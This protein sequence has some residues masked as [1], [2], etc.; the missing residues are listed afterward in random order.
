MDIH[1]FYSFMFPMPDTG[2]VSAKIVQMCLLRCST[3][4]GE[5]AFVQAGV[6]ANQGA[7]GIQPYFF[8]ESYTVSNNTFSHD[9]WHQLHM[10]IAV[11]ADHTSTLAVWID[12]IPATMSAKT[13]TWT[14]DLDTV[15]VGTPSTNAVATFYLKD[16]RLEY[17]DTGYTPSV[18][19]VA[20]WGSLVVPQTN[21]SVK[22]KSF[23]AANVTATLHYGA[24]DEYGTDVVSAVA[25]K[26]HEA[27]LTGL[28]PAVTYHYQ[29][30]FV[31]EAATG[32]TWKTE[33]RT[34]QLKA[35]AVTKL[36]IVSDPQGSGQGSAAATQYLNRTAGI[37]GIITPG[38][39]C[40]VGDSQVPAN[41]WLQPWALL[42]AL[43]NTANRSVWIPAIGNHDTDNSGAQPYYNTR[44]M[45][46]FPIPS[47]EAGQP[48]YSIDYGYAH[49]AVID[50]TEGA[51]GVSISA[52]CLAWLEA[53][54]KVSEKPWKF[55][56]GH[57]GGVDMIGYTATVPWLS[58]TSRHALHAAMLA[59]KAHMYIHG[60]SHN[61]VRFMTG[62]ILYLGMSCTGTPGNFG[63]TALVGEE[64][65]LPSG[66]GTVPAT[67]KLGAYGVLAVAE[68]T[69]AINVYRD[70]SG[71]QIDAF[72]LRRRAGS[73]ALARAART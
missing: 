35:D 21:T 14:A 1:L 16:L 30:E 19:L 20:D 66:Y 71:A 61:Y 29:W 31:S 40:T 64:D 32:D 18:P 6:S 60:H 50:T 3:S 58:E 54:L 57:N 12:G 26:A 41:D 33:D 44:I 5:A 52:A 37:D 38:D 45:G 67:I 27:T 7:A 73:V 15:M 17:G 47:V 69:L 49:Y 59:G 51:D 11:A 42:E 25:A 34:F 68:K 36:A 48:Y 9:R 10:K 65:Y 8:N 62:G 22:I 28:D 23:A 70:T 39:I 2:T 53:D 46:L 56:V 4:T 72:V 13:K 43:G 24:D 63:P 55:V